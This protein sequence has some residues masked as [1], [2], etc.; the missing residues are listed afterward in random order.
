MSRAFRCNQNLTRPFWPARCS[1]SGQGT[2]ADARGD[3][4]RRGCS[5]MSGAP[6]GQYV[7][8]PCA[9]SRR[10]VRPVAGVRCVPV[11][12]Q[13]P[14]KQRSRSAHRRP[15]GQTEPFVPVCGAQVRDVTPDPKGSG[16]SG[17]AGDGPQFPE[18]SRSARHASQS[19]GVSRSRRAW[20]PGRGTRCT[21]SL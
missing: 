10:R 18:E 4:V 13:G 1:G 9:Y 20:A 5:G 3:G 8:T 14:Y 2:V 16:R 17:R 19:S 6:E 11:E 21:W 15:C 7:Q 12:A